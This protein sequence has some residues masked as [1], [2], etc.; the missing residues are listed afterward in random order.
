VKHT[1]PPGNRGPV[2]RCEKCKAHF[3][4]QAKCPSCGK[5]VPEVES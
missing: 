1:R 2:V 5:A 4:W 3:Y